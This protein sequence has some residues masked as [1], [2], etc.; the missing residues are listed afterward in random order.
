MAS[1]IRNPTGR[2]SQG[3]ALLVLEATAL[4]Y[5]VYM[6][7]GTWPP[8]H[9][10]IALVALALATVLWSGATS[11]IGITISLS[12]AVVGLAAAWYEGVLHLFF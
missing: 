2:V 4:T 7:R 6:V 11:P 8:G 12:G 9:P 10:W 1:V 5:A 3:M